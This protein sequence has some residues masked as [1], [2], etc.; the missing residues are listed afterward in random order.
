MTIL[1]LN[2]KIN[3]PNFLASTRK[4]IIHNYISKFELGPGP[5][6]PRG[7]GP[8]FIPLLGLGPGR[9]IYYTN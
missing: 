6:E 2:I 4:I 1:I 9:G 8:A 5:I 3:I 7:V